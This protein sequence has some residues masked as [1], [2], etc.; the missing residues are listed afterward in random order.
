MKAQEL[1]NQNFTVLAFFGFQDQINDFEK[2][3]NIHNHFYLK[4]NVSD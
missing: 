2:V 4:S 1:K 3:G